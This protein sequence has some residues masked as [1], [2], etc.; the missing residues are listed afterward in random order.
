[1][2]SNMELEIQSALRLGP[3]GPQ[4]ASEP[5]AAKSHAKVSGIQMPVVRVS[6]ESA[7]VA[8]RPGPAS[9]G[10]K[11]LRK[12]ASLNESRPGFR[13]SESD[14]QTDVRFGV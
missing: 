10:F 9:R 5:A 2:Q 1:M 8:L 4:P 12:L 11:F 6:G 3:A 14:C 13:V 7:A